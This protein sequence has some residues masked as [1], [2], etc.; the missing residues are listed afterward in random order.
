MENKQYSLRVSKNIQFIVAM[1][2]LYTKY[3]ELESKKIGTYVCN[4]N[5][6]CIF[7]TIQEN[8]LI[9]GNIIVIIISFFKIIL[10]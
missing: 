2:N 5:K 8:E 10:F 9:D 7:D 3:P 6:V 1:H 4:G